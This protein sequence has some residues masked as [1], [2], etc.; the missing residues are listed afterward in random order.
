[1]QRITISIGPGELLDRLSILSIKLS[2]A[3]C[4]DAQSAISQ[5]ITRLN[6]QCRMLGD[7]P[8]LDELAEEL[9][10]INRQLWDVEDELR[11]L[12]ADQN[13]G[14]EFVE[15]ARS[16]YRL[17][18]RRAMVRAQIDT[19]C[20]SEITDYKFYSSDVQAEDASEFCC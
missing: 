19:V 1:M 8:E 2:F 18:D 10:S 20:E 7:V 17:N 11:A 13:F 14:L 3:A 12:E 6:N 16:V 5:Q 4:P 9:A 15:L